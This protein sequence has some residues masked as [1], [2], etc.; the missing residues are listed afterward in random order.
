[1]QEHA[2]PVIGN[3]YLLQYPVKR[4][5][6]ISRRISPEALASQKEELLYASDHGAVLVSPCISPGVAAQAKVHPPSDESAPLIEDAASPQV[7]GRHTSFPG[8]E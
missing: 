4:Q 2:C 3:R 7:V 1:M 5:V 8:K 6:Q